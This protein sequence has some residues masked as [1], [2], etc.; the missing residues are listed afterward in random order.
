MFLK[1]NSNDCS[2]IVCMFIF[3]RRYVYV[4][5]ISVEF[6]VAKLNEMHFKNINGL[7]DVNIGSEK[8]LY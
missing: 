8:D 3:L 6:P 1:I 7:F 4:K 2:K 5:K